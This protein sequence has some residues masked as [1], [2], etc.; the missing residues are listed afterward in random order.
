LPEFTL[1]DP[2]KY[3]KV[4]TAVKSALT[5]TFNKMIHKTPYAIGGGKKAAGGAPSMGPNLDG[6]ER[7][8]RL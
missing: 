8:L 7:I 3:T 6:N 2:T 5:R 1:T 4:A